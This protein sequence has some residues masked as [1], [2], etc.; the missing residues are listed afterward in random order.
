M[1]KAACDNII[2]FLGGRRK[3]SKG[4]EGLT[5]NEGAS[6][7]ITSSTVTPEVGEERREQEPPVPPTPSS[8]TR[9]GGGKPEEFPAFGQSGGS[10][11]SAWGKGSP[12]KGARPKDKNHKTSGSSGTTE[13]KK[14][15]TSGPKEVP[16][17][18][19]GRMKDFSVEDGRGRHF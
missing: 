7:E 17:R 11:E 16:T 6:G 5:V 13:E 18:G 15:E 12:W 1:T 3:G 9:A 2:H 8:G 14:M 19:Q 10:F 4:S